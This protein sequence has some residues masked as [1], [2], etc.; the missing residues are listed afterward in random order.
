LPAGTVGKVY[1]IKDSVGDAAN[2]PITIVGSI[3]G[4][5]SYVINID[6]ASITLVFNG[7]EWNVV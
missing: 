3:D 2:N 1:V 4:G 7:I 6:W 5:A